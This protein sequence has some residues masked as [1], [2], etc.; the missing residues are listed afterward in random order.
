MATAKI[1]HQS[2]SFREKNQ[3]TEGKNLTPQL[4]TTECNEEQPLRGADA[5][6]SSLEIK[7]KVALPGS[8]GGS[9]RTNLV[10][11]DSHPI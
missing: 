1:I 10:T 9:K 11:P 2:P 3:N 7:L 6:S 8:G 4:L 5:L